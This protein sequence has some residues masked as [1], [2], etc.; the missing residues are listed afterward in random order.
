MLSLSAAIYR[1]D[2]CTLCM[3]LAHVYMHRTKTSRTARHR[4]PTHK[5]SNTRRRRSPRKLVAAL[6]TTPATRHATATQH[7]AGTRVCFNSHA[8]PLRSAVRVRVAKRAGW[9]LLSCAVLLRVRKVVWSSVSF[10]VLTVRRVAHEAF[11]RER[12]HRLMQSKAN[13]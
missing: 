7:A 1:L 2:W 12:V 6:T 8:H 13:R 10:L 11:Q 4:T 5:Q 9:L 3:R